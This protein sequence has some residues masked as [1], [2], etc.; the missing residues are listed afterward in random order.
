[1]AGGSKLATELDSSDWKLRWNIDFAYIR[2][3]DFTIHDIGILELGREQTHLFFDHATLLND[4][5]LQNAEIVPICLGALELHTKIDKDTEIRQLGWGTAYEE[6]PLKAYTGGI[7]DPKYSTCMTSQASPDTWRFQN[8]DMR[9]LKTPGKNIWQCEKNRRPPDYEK[10]KV[11]IC[12]DYFDIASKVKDK[13]NPGKTL[14]E[15]RLKDIDFIDVVIVENGK[16]KKEK[17]FNPTLLSNFGWCFLYDFRE[18]HDKSY[19]M[20][21]NWQGGK[22]WG[23]CSPS[24]DEEYTKVS[25]LK[26]S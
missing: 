20:Q 2:S 15:T 21:Q 6:F 18:K 16:A 19:A 22:A 3:K 7:R 24:C 11:K 23:I 14:S 25:D 5:K 12:K 8:C 1:M 13:A 4:I 17:C 10:G 9:K 26:A